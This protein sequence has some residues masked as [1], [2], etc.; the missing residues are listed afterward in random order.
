MIAI[1]NWP[2]LKIAIL[3]IKRHMT[4]QTERHAFSIQKNKIW[5]KIWK[6]ISGDI[7]GIV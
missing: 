6:P 2:E 1:P 3:T 4:K 7:L 5:Y